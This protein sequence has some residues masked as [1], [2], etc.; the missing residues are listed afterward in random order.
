MKR[1][2]FWLLMF[3]ALST[4]AQERKIIGRVLS[5]ET[6]KPVKNANVIILGATSGTF[7][8]AAGFFELSIDNSKYEKLMVSHIGY[9][10]A[11]IPIPLQDRFMF[12][13][14][15]EYTV[16]KRINLAGYPVVEQIM[17]RTSTPASRESGEF[18]VVESGAVFPGG[19]DNFYVYLGNALANKSTGKPTNP[20]DCRFTINTDGKAEDVSISDS[21]T[22]G[23]ANEVRQIFNDMDPWIPGTQRGEMVP[24]YF[25]IKI[26]LDDWPEENRAAVYPYLTLL[27]YPKE[28]RKMGVQGSVV[29]RF[30][31]EH[32]IV[33]KI[34]FLEDIGSG[35]AEMVRRAITQVPVEKMKLLGP[36]QATYVLAVNFGLDTKFEAPDPI[37]GPNEVLLESIY[38]TA[39]G[40]KK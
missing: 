30:S 26:A 15:R 22:V 1:I 32:G 17:G 4:N 19:M 12:Y 11:N 36:P 21:T 27:S 5:R 37:P 33:T 20:F 24:Q 2:L 7:T 13:L 25:Q 28:A 35:C 39:Q 34:E 8:N 29:V 14:D 40:S 10:T 3:F 38:F 18:K 16:L 31:V 6:K 23:L 9:Q